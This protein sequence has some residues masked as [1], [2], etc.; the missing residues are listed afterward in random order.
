[1][2]TDVDPSRSAGGI[3]SRRAITCLNEFTFVLNF[4]QYQS[5]I[6]GSILSLHVLMT[7]FANN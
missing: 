1:V 3:S 7:G 5:S 2:R 6:F 4:L